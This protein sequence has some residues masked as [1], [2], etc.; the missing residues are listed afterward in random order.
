MNY[1][2]FNLKDY[3]ELFVLSS[4]MFMLEPNMLSALFD[5]RAEL[6]IGLPQIHPLTF[7]YHSFEFFTTE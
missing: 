7:L 6:F 3:L 4:I 2:E 1:R 5:Q